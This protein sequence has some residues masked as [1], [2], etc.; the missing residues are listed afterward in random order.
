MCEHAF[1][2]R[3]SQTSTNLVLGFEVRTLLAHFSMQRFDS[4]SLFVPTPVAFDLA[5]QEGR[6]FCVTKI[7]ELLVVH[8]MVERQRMMQRCL[9]HDLKRAHQQYLETRPI[10]AQFGP[11]APINLARLTLQSFLSEERGPKMMRDS[12]RWCS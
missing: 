10:V 2:G 6:R 11:T 1:L 4:R 3:E 5:I 12:R 9:C 7:V 8:L